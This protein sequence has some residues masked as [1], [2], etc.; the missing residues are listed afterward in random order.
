M[1]EEHFSDEA[2]L[3]SKVG[4]LDLDELSK[5]IIVVGE[6]KKPVN[7]LSH[8]DLDLLLLVPLDI[9]EL[10]EYSDVQELDQ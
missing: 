1:V 4:Q 7:E 2:V 10:N 3:D 6:E 8:G 9:V 5:E